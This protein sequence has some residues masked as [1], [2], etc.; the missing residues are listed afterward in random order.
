MYLN[1]LKISL[2]TPSPLADLRKTHL[3]ILDNGIVFRFCSAAF[4][5]NAFDTKNDVFKVV[6]TISK[7]ADLKVLGVQLFKRLHQKVD[8]KSF[9]RSH[10]GV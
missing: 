8:L 6:R 7:K 3:L 9:S 1:K 2:T 4:S 5:Y 10:R